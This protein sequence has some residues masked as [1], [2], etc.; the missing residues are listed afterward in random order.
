MEINDFI[1]S[2]ANIFDETEVEELTQN[3]I[4]HELEE[5]GSLTA[6]GLIAL[7]RTNYGKKITGADIRT[8]T[9]IQDLYEMITKK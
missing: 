8:C 6:M 5:W 7:V 4:F 3:C 2:F 9:T 1:S